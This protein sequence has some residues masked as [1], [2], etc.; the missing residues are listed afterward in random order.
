VKIIISPSK[1]M[2]NCKSE[3][4]SRKDLLYLKEHKEILSTLQLL[5]K[6]E[7][8]K[9]LNIKGNIL[10]KTYNNILNYDSLDE[11]QAF[12]SFN[13]LVFK[14]LDINAY[15]E[16]EYKY[17][18]KNLLILDAF[19]G[20][21]EPGTFIKPYRLDMKAKIGIKLYDYWQL[22]SYFHNEVIINLASTEYSKMLGTDLIN[23]HFLQKKN[24]KYV[25]QATYSKMARGLFLD[26][27]I[28]NKISNINNLKDFN[29]DK[30]T[31][32]KD[33]SDE[34]NITFTR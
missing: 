5:S 2:N 19:Y 33:L 15:L 32:N 3:F 7:L 4:L 18:A 14:N 12:P 13:G 16:D 9:G 10:E 1:T 21:I 17:I 22:D 29:L 28:K 24:N 25:N 34:S 23:V 20:I 26:Y 6:E 30:Y 11:I 31:Y 8:S 27:M